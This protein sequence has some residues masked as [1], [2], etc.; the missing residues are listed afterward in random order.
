MPAS[1][2]NQRIKYGKSKT[3]SILIAKVEKGLLK[4]YAVT[5]ETAGAYCIGSADS[6]CV[7]TY[8]RGREVVQL[9]QEFKL[10]KTIILHTNGRMK[11]A[12]QMLVANVILLPANKYTYTHY[13][14]K[15]KYLSRRD[16][17]WYK[18]FFYSTKNLYHSK[19]SS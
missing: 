16:V 17:V 2:N 5:T 6:Q 11:S 9:S 10:C 12:Q 18:L 13:Q 8:K 7:S 3:K 19:S 14:N 1:E 15:L 4:T